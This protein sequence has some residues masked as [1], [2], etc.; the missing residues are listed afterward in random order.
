V[1]SLVLIGQEVSDLQGVNLGLL[2][3]TGRPVLTTLLAH[4]RAASE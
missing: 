1:L 3:L 2:A 4:Y